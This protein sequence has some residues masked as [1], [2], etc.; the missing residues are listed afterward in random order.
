MV[1]KALLNAMRKT[2]QTRQLLRRIRGASA[3]AVGQLCVS[4]QGLCAFRVPGT[5]AVDL[6]TTTGK[7]G[8]N[9]RRAVDRDKAN[10]GYDD[11]SGAA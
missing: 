2:G 6:L 4:N 3:N 11:G 5:A 1:A 7:Q 9:D 10:E 8:R